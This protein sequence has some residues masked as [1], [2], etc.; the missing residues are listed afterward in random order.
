MEEGKSK[1]AEPVLRENCKKKRWKCATE[2][3]AAQ[4][5][6]LDTH[7]TGPKRALAATMRVSLLSEGGK[8][9]KS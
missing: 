8:S 1:E 2:L 6:V 9:D 7:I 4:S 5:S 3:S